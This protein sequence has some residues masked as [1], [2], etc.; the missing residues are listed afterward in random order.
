MGKNIETP[1]PVEANTVASR[2]VRPALKATFTILGS[3]IGGA[4]V[5]TLA[6][7][8]FGFWPQAGTGHPKIVVP[9]PSTTQS[10]AVAQQNNQTRPDTPGTTVANDPSRTTEVGGN[11]LVGTSEQG[12]GEACRAVVDAFADGQATA[13]QMITAAGMT[14]D[15]ELSG[16]ISTLAA[17]LKSGKINGTEVSAVTN[18]CNSLEIAF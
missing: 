9:A 6:A 13:D 12:R 17:H 15:K 4:L 18:Y 16:L 1:G 8:L 10:P 3:F 7:A 11:T 14:S 5:V 2:G